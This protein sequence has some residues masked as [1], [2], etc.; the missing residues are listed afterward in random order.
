MRKVHCM[1][2]KQRIYI[3]YGVIYILL[4][5][6]VYSQQGNNQ[7]TEPL[8]TTW[9]IALDKLEKNTIKNNA[10]VIEQESKK[11]SEISILETEEYGWVLSYTGEESQEMYTRRLY[12]FLVTNGYIHGDTSINR[13]EVHKGIA[14]F[15]RNKSLD[16]CTYEAAQIL[17]IKL[18]EH[19]VKSYGFVEDDHFNIFASEGSD[20]KNP[21]YSK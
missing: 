15:N 2:K 10:L 16:Y 19:E 9:D 17:A 20:S 11:E 14:N 3:I 12:W 21:H 4:I 1:K 5:F 7:S 6:P 8:Q 18:K 13:L